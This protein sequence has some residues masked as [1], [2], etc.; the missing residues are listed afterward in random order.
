MPSK[1]KLPFC[2]GAGGL[3]DILGLFIIPAA[4]CPPRDPIPRLGPPTRP[5]IFIPRPI[6]DMPRPIILEP[7][8]VPRPLIIPRHN[9]S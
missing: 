6:G 1:S 7:R 8:P 4:C 9:S 2:I 5:P 3:V